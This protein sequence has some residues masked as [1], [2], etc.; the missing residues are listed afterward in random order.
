MNDPSICG[1]WWLYYTNLVQAIAKQEEVPTMHYVCLNSD[2][3]WI[4]MSDQSDK[5][6]L[7]ILEKL[8]FDISYFEPGYVYKIRITPDNWIAEDYDKL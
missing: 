3:T 5:E 7:G 6:K 1:T 8:P 4:L 2:N